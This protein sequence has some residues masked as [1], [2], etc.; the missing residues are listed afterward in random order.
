MKKFLTILMGSLLAA[1][2]AVPLSAS[3]T[4]L[5]K[6][7]KTLGLAG[8]Y[9]S[10]NRSGYSSVYFQYTFVP[11]VRIAPEFGYVFRSHDKTGFE[12]SCDMHFPFRIVRGFNIYPLV[13]VTLNTWNYIHG[14]S[15]TRFGGDMGFGFD[16][17]IT[18]NLK[19]NIQAKYSVM[20]NTSGAFAGVGIGYVF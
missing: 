8:G 18:S 19:F 13:G 20:K 1:S 17:Y 15:A 6:G 2:A 5:T 7:E 12:I 11:H 9:A 14:G 4:S 10:Y 16:L 3:A